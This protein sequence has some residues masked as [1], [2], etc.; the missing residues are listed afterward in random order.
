MKKQ[1]D[2]VSVPELVA[3]DANNEFRNGQEN[4]CER[5]EQRGNPRIDSL[6]GE[7]DAEV[8]VACNGNAAEQ[9]EREDHRYVGSAW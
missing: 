9:H 8:V 7:Q 6:G 5:D 1:N 4:T 3:D 2:P